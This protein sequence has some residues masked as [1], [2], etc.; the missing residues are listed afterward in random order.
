MTTTNIEIDDEISFS[1]PSELVPIFNEV[2]KEY[3]DFFG[4]D[5]F[6][7]IHRYQNLDKQI[8][9]WKMKH[10]ELSVILSLNK[11]PTGKP[12]GVLNAKYMNKLQIIQQFYFRLLQ[13]TG[14]LPKF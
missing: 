4:F 7:R 14:A 5:M 12:I 2:R 6:D 13:E 10:D 9:Y 3:A 11:L 8:N 1:L